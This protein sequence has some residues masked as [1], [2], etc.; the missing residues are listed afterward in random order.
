MLNK[1]IL[2]AA[3]AAALMTGISLA[4][5]D[6][7]SSDKGYTASGNVTLITDYKFRGIS[8]SNS[9]PT[10]QGGLDVSWDS[11]FYVGTWAAAVDFESRALLPGSCCDG[12]LELDYYA[13]WANSIGDTG[14][15]VDVGYAYYTYP[16]DKNSD[17]NFGELY[18]NST[19]N[20][21]KIGVHYTNEY[22]LKSGETWYTYGEYS[23]T[24]PWEVSLS[25][26]AGYSFLEKNGG[27]LS[28]DTDTYYDYSISASKE[29]WGFDWTLSY[30]DA[31][32]DEDDLF[33]KDWG[34]STAIFS[35]GRSF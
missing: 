1:K 2:A 28:S 15:D 18:A 12:S 25:L 27:F 32:L 20:N 8:Q 13:G 17:A 34:D 9:D 6:D 10:V 11:G 3:V 14:F 4:Q 21:L 35:I 26:H 23:M 30:V 16:A 5:A 19:W 22:Y 29:L 33:G 31:D 7:G 24:L